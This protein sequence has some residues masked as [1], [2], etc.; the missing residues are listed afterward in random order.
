MNRVKMLLERFFDNQT[1]GQA[2]LANL[3]AARVEGIAEGTL[4][5]TPKEASIIE[6]AT[7]N[8][9]NAELLLQLNKDD[10]AAGPQA[11]GKSGETKTSKSPSTSARG[12]PPH[13]RGW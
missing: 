1:Y 5:I 6:E 7:E 11:E 13:R 9:V 12:N 4:K 3:D 2:L 10:L 8:A